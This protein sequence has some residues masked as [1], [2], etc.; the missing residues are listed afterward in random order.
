[1]IAT[2]K[3]LMVTTAYKRYD[4]DV[5]TP[6]LTELILRLRDKKINVEVFTSSYKGL[7][8]QTVDGVKVH[9]F[10]YSPKTL[11]NLTHDETVADKLSHSPFSLILI[12]FYMIAGLTN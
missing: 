12:L 5:I 9:R 7:R 6:W 10:R 8:D 11:E 1:M 3:V 2:M 4:G